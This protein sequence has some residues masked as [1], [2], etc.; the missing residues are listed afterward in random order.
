MQKNGFKKSGNIIFF[1]SSSAKENNFG[2]SI[3]SASKSAIESMS[4]SLSKEL[5]R[6]NIRVNTIAP[7]PVETEMFSKF[8]DEENTKKIINRTASKK[9]CKNR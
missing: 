8:T 6:Y 4:K 2:R 3:Y 9:N 5:G 1:S 7:G